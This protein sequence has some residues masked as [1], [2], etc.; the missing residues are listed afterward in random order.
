MKTA[1]PA[2][3]K[4]MPVNTAATVVPTQSVL[5]QQPVVGGKI[6][7]VGM[8]NTTNVNNSN[9]SPQPIVVATATKSIVPSPAPK[10]VRS[11]HPTAASSSQPAASSSTTSTTTSTTNAIA[12]LFGVTLRK[13][14]NPPPDIQTH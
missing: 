14:P 12:S 8:V 4:V 11:Y 2:P 13:T 10:P 3:K 9:S 1:A 5:L 6:P 7:L